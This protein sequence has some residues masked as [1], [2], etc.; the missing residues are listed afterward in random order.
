MRFIHENT[1]KSMKKLKYLSLYHNNLG[2]LITENKKAFENLGSLKFLFLN[3]NGI[4]T[5][6]YDF[7]K[8]M[9][10]LLHLNLA[11][12]QITVVDFSLMSLGDLSYLDLSSNNIATITQDNLQFLNTLPVLGLDLHRNKLSCTCSTKKFLY[13]LEVTSVY[14]LDKHNLTCRYQNKSLVNLANSNFIIDQLTYD[15]SIDEILLFTCIVLSMSVL[16]LSMLVVIFRKRWQIK[17]LYYIGKKSINPHH[18]LEGVNVKRGVDVFISYDIDEMLTP[19]I[20]IH[21][22]V[23]EV[24]NPFLKR[25]NFVVKIREDKP[26]GRKVNFELATILQSSKKLVAF[27]SPNYASDYWNLFEFNMSVLEGINTKRKSLLEILTVNGSIY[28]LK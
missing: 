9:S 16:S 6:P 12:N 4:S 14:V 11:E 20:R 2:D 10:S 22:F 21:N 27:L 13:W 19:T 25:K 18:P 24:V 23:A 15:C 3:N 8:S 1:F 28:Q 17:Y 26:P 7:F 5:I